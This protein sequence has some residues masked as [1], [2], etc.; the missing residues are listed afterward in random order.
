MASMVLFHQGGYLA[1]GPA[2]QRVILAEMDPAVDWPD[3]IDPAEP[4][5]A[6]K[7]AGVSAC[8]IEPEAPACCQKAV[9]QGDLRRGDA[10]FAPDD[11]RT[12][13]IGIA[14]ASP[15]AFYSGLGFDL[16]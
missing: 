1:V 13:A 14:L 10:W 4:I 12:A 16:R 11:G 15:A 5:L 6:Q 7:L 3:R 8:V 9:D 2:C